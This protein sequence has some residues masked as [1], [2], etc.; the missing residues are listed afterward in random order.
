MTSSLNGATTYFLCFTTGRTGECH[1][2]K[3]VVTVVPFALGKARGVLPVAASVSARLDYLPAAY[4]NEF[5]I[6]LL[7]TLFRLLILLVHELVV[8]FPSGCISRHAVA[9]RRLT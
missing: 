6:D 3:R 8:N 5:P 9:Q 1:L 4:S 7:P 2:R